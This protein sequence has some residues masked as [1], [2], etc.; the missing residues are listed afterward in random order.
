VVARW[1]RTT[2]KSYFLR[3]KISTLSSHKKLPKEK[4]AFF[5]PA[6]GFFT[7]PP[8]PSLSGTPLSSQID[9]VILDFG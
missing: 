2:P 3:R 8:A 1:E 5:P 4:K 7:T 6:A 9:R